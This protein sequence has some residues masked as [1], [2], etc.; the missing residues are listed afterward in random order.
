MVCKGFSFNKSSSKVEIWNCFI[1][2]LEVF[3]HDGAK[4]SN[5]GAFFRVDGA[6]KSNHGAFFRV[7][8]AKKSNHGAVFRKNGAI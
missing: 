5:H 7:D 1:L 3:R 2:W 6:K 4:K 8:G